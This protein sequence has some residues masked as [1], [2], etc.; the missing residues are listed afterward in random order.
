MLLYQ[1]VQLYKF[2]LPRVYIPEQVEFTIPEEVV[3]LQSICKV[4]L[5]TSTTTTK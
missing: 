1:R 3:E 4:E 2:E 5:K